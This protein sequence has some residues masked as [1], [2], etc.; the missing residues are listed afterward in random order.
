MLK[1]SERHYRSEAPS[2]VLDDFHDAL[3]RKYG[4]DAVRKQGRSINIDFGV[5]VDAEDNTDYRVL[6]VDAVPAFAE[7]DDDYE[8]PDIDSGKWI[9]TN[10]KIHALTRRLHGPPGLLERMERPGAHGQVLEQQPEATAPKSQ[11]NRP[12]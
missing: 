6:S 12:F 1:D 2:V 7:G 4:K 3:V 8:I 11:S 5:V 10:P 9:K